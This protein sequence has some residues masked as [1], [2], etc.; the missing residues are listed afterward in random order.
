M[1]EPGGALPQLI[2]AERPQR[3]REPANTDEKEEPPG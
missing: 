2:A 1:R 3:A